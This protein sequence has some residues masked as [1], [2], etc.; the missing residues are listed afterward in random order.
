MTEDA[1]L[2]F[3]VLI[4]GGGPAGLSTAIQLAQLNKQHNTNLS[5]CVLEKGA[6]IG[7]HILSGCV[8]NP[9]SLN[10]LIPNWKSLDTPIKT[11]VTEDKFYW[12][13]KRYA[14]RTPVPP[15]MYNHGNYLI[16]LSKLC[17]WLGQ[18]A[19]SLGVT[20]I[21]GYAAQKPLYDQQ[22]IFIGIET[23]EVGRQK[24]GQK[25]PRYQ[26]GIPI[27]AK[28]TVLAEGCAGSITEQVIDKYQLRAQAQPQN[29]AIGVKEVWQVPSPNPQ[30][31]LCIHTIG[32]PLDPHTYGGG[33][34]FYHIEDKIAIGIVVGLDYTNP[35]LDAHGELQ[36]FKMHPLIKKISTKEN[37][38]PMAHGH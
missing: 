35:T 7:A 4:I 16:S 8:F 12:L 37:V 20:V 22:D 11:A 33:F 34:L 2:S 24:N 31:G 30:T 27:F 19:Q 29:Y 14:I 1:Q 5:I 25:G 17:R 6:E 10:Q 36:K 9:R 26:A 28:Q 13:T 21:A 15:Q 32:W 18:Y 3:D 38:L 23:G